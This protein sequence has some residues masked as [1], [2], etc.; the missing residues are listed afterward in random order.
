LT[1]AAQDL[2]AAKNLPRAI[3]V[4]ERLLARTP[5]V[6]LPKQRIGWTIIGQSQ[7]DLAVYDQ[8]E[9]AFVRALAVADATAPE[10]ADVTERL[11]SAVYRQAEA[12]RKAGDEAGA[13]DDFL[14]VAAVAPASKVVATSQYDAAAALL[15]TKQWTRAI[16]VLEN[17]RRDYPQSE[18]APEVTR[19]LAVAYVEAGMSAQAATEFERMAAVPGEEPAVVR[20]ALTRAADLYQAAG[21]GTRSV[22][23]LEQLV[24]KFPTPVSDAI[25]TRARP[26]ISPS[27]PATASACATGRTKS[28]RPMPVPASGAPIAR[29]LAATAR[30]AQVAPRAMH[31]ARYA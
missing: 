28:S 1:R 14:R 10:R 16:A 21:N 12:K 8:A 17:Y 22:A 25:E 7:F 15:T 11:A 18:Y 29:F 19:K 20:E 23:M 30:L 26:R 24:Q 6:D 4:S 3:E 2:F 31:S 13:A 5:P 9:T 27:G